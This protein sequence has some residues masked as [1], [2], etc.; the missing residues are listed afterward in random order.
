MEDEELPPGAKPS[1]RV[2]VSCKNQFPVSNFYIKDPKVNRISTKCKSCEQTIKK[3]W[4]SKNKDQNNSY[5]KSWQNSNREKHNLN[6][7]CWQKRNK[8]YKAKQ[9]SMKR[10]ILKQRMLP[11]ITPQQEKEIESFYW[12]ARD[13]EMLTGDKYHVDHI[14]PVRGKTVCGLHVPWN[15]QI[16]PS[17]LNRK[18]SNSYG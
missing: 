10:A 15:L 8:P 6:N 14:I 2:C 1:D 5:K 18:K 16:L 7:R 11:W 9:Q 13:C 17:D 3:L 4:L 12:L